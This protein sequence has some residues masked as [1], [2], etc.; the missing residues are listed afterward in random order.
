MKS[1]WGRVESNNRPTDFQSVTLPLSY[2]PVKDEVEGGIEPPYT[3]LQTVAFNHSTTPPYISA[4]HNQIRHPIH[5]V[6]HKGFLRQL[7]QTLGQ[8]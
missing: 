8:R 2:Y 7:E 4:L 5:K 6:L 3:V 1:L